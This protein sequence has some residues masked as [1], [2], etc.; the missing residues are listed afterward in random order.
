MKPAVRQSY[1][2]QI[3]KFAALIAECKDDERRAVLERNLE[4]ERQLLA[5]L[6]QQ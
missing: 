2:R 3:E 4:I 6:D 5:R 1:V